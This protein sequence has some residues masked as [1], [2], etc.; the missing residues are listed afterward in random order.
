MIDFGRR[1]AASFGIVGGFAVAI[2]MVLFLPFGAI[3]VMRLTGWEWWAA[4]AAL[5]AL[6]LIPLAGQVAAVGLAVFGAFTLGQDNLA[7]RMATRPAVLQSVAPPVGSVSNAADKFTEWKKTVAA[8]AIQKSCLEDVQRRGLVGG[9]QIDQMAR[10]CA[11]YGAAAVT[12]ITPDDVEDEKLQPGPDFNE[13]LG[14]EAKRL[15]QR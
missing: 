2:A 13:R 10:A 11:C 9:A 15:C 4:L 7:Q 8:P 3:A 14:V 12:V 6:N 1:V 5:I